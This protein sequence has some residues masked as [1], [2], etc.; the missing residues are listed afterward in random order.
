MDI[1]NN[2][3]TD[4][5][6]LAKQTAIVVVTVTIARGTAAAGITAEKGARIEAAEVAGGLDHTIL[7]GIL[8]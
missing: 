3:C 7:L 1:S 2:G 4:S 5:C 8:K 6:K